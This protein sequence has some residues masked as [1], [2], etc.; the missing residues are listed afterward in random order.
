[1]DSIESM[2]TFEIEGPG[3]IGGYYTPAE[4]WAHADTTA[5]WLVRALHD[6]GA[7]AGDKE[8]ETERRARE[9]APLIEQV[10]GTHTWVEGGHTV[11]VIRLHP[12]ARVPDQMMRSMAHRRKI[13]QRQRQQ[14]D[15]R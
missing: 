4:E 12:S 6:F 2:W 13:R 1:M 10:Q 14:A 5:R 7:I 8:I 11:T 9:L 3:Y 15:D